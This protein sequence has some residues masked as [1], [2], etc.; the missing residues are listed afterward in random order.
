MPVPDWALRILRLSWH[1]PPALV[2][3]GKI[4]AALVFCGLGILLYALIGEVDALDCDRATGLCTLTHAT[5]TDS[6]TRQFPVAE[7]TGARLEYGGL[8]QGGWKSRSS[9]S[10]K[11]ALITRDETI[12]F[13]SFATSFKRDQMKRQLAEI[14]EFARTPSRPSLTIRFDER[15]LAAL[16]GG[17]FFLFGVAALVATL[18]G[19]M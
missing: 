15:P 1:M 4:L 8:S 6:R 16:V 10:Q 9:G 18:R 17:V 5:P 2:R 3:L 11:I 14:Q 13:T 7:L 12:P 19:G